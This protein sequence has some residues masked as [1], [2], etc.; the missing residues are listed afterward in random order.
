MNFLPQSFA[1]FTAIGLWRPLNWSSGLKKHLY[2]CYTFFILVIV[3]F[4]G[5]MEFVDAM[6]NFGN[7]EEMVSASFMLLTTGNAFCKAV[8][9]VSRRNEIISIFGILDDDVCRRKNQEEE[10]IQAKINIRIR[11]NA[12]WYF[13]IVQSAVVMITMSSIIQ[14]VPERTLPFRAWIPLNYSTDN[15]YWCVYHYQVIAHAAVAI[16]SI[17]YDTMV[18]GIMLLT[19]A[20]LKIFKYRCKN[21]PSN[22]DH[23]LKKYNSSRLQLERKILKQS[24]WHHEN[25]IHVYRLSGMELNNP[26]FPF[27]LFYLLCMINQIFCFC[28]YGNEVMLEVR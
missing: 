12:A 21:L 28:W 8:N 27:A 18:P 4:F 26:E 5:L 13:C 16:I 20:Q 24:V 10:D 22:V 6:S 9:M 15:V 25:I 1:I 17:A 11:N 19:G 23:E 2:D 7:L 3:Y 14:N